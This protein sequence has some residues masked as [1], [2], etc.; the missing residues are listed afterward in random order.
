MTQK[1]VVIASKAGT[2]GKTV[3]ASHCLYPRMPGARVMAVDTANI[4]AKHFGIPTETFGGN[5]FNRLFAEI[6][7]DT[8]SDMIIDVG[9]SKECVEFIAGMRQTKGQTEI[10]HFIVP[11]MPEFKDQD[12]AMD[13]IELLL[14]QKV[15]PNRIKV[16]FMKFM[17]N[18]KDE[19]DH[20]LRGME[21]LKVPIELKASVEFTPLFDI[22]TTHGVSLATMLAD[23]T[24]YKE[25]L[26]T[27]EKGSMERDRCIDMRIAQG[28]AEEVNE[29]LQTV[30]NALFP[31]KKSA[32]K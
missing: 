26:L 25:K 3:L 8:E 15:D 13:T 11:A 32:T 22:L 20:V 19:F 27:Y 17:R 5:E 6:M 30:F 16:V 7:N 12:A 23:K 9:G 18:V 10:T 24:D 21:Y 1:I 28:S 14:K 4:T 29:I 2:V 31:T